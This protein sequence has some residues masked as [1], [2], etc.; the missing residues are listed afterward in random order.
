MRKQLKYRTFVVIKSKTG[1]TWV[2]ILEEGM[3]E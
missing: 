2:I 1:N 3:S